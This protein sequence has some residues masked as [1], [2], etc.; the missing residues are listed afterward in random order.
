[1]LLI[2]PGPDAA[3]WPVVTAAW[4]AYDDAIIRPVHPRLPPT[5]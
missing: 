3:G 2:H 5:R 1:M 4:P